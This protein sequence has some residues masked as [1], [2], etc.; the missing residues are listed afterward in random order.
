MSDLLVLQR[1]LRTVVASVCMAAALVAAA[2]ARPR[3]MQL[4]Q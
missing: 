3:T 2:H 4:A 1:P